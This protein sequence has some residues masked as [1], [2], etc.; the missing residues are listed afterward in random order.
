MVLNSIML[1]GNIYTILGIEQGCVRNFR[2]CKFRWFSASK[3]LIPTPAS[4]EIQFWLFTSIPQQLWYRT[5]KSLL[6]HSWIPNFIE[7]Y[8][9]FYV[10]S[11]LILHK[12]ASLKMQ[13][14]QIVVIKKK[15]TQTS[16]KSVSNLHCIG[17]KFDRKVSIMR[18]TD[19][20]QRKYENQ[21]QDRI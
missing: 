20:T 6:F 19:S 12:C 17:H 13:R 14:K 18:Q 9:T 3:F 2:F 4:R 10:I 15:K 5:T 7:T 8:I 11:N 16:A 1:L 21:K